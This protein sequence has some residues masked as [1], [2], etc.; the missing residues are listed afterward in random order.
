MHLSAASLNNR[1]Q[2]V[3]GGTYIDLIERLQY[4]GIQWN[5]VIDLVDK[6]SSKQR[7]AALLWEDDALFDLN[8]WVD[9]PRGFDYLTDAVDI[10]DKG[11]I[12]AVAEKD[13]IQRGVLLIPH[14]ENPSN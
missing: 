7:S 3:G 10:N 11:W 2:I 8:D 6:F 14:G 13:D 12:V 1:G 9:L 4:W 5:W